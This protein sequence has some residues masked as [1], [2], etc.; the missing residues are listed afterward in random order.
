LIIPMIALVVAQLACGGPG[1]P[2]TSFA[3]V[4]WIVDGDGNTI[5]NAS[6]TI[7]SDA[8]FEASPIN[9]SS[10]SDETGKFESEL[11]SG[12]TCSNFTIS[13]SVEGYETYT[14]RYTPPSLATWNPYELAITLNK[15]DE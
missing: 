7:Q 11:I 14:T 5:P 8:E 15:A 12:S 2:V 1:C 4:G 9:I 6:V 3:V 10:I 13:V